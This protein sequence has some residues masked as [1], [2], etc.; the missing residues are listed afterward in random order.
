MPVWAQNPLRLVFDTWFERPL[1]MVSRCRTASTPLVAGRVVA[2]GG[3][4]CHQSRRLDRLSSQDRPGKAMVRAVMV[5]AR[6]LGL[7]GHGDHDG[8]DG[9]PADDHDDE[10]S[11]DAVYEVRVVPRRFRNLKFDVSLRDDVVTADGVI[12]D[13]HHHAYR[14]RDWHA[15]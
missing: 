11:C 6:I 5:V 9:V 1:A 15:C 10:S 13:V 14:C 8:H 2:V 12:L 4:D 7:D 3:N